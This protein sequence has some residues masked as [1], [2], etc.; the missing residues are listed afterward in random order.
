[1]INQNLQNIDQYNVA[2]DELHCLMSQVPKSN[3]IEDKRLSFLAELIR[4]YEQN[5]LERRNEKN[6]KS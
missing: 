6:I 1:M 2:L 5:I 3:T 4:S